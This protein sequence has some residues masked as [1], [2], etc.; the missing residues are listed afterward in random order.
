MKINVMSLLVDDQAKA[1]RFYTEQLGFIKK[2]D[3]PLG[4]HKWLTVVSNEERDGVELLLEPI[5]FPPAQI[6][7]KALFDAGIPAAS[8]TVDDIHNE[9][10]RLAKAGVQFSMKPTVMGPVTLAVFRDTCGNNIQIVQV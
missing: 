4:D 5:A 6:Y 2:T 10:D 7:Q 9:Y 1:L 8:F 3:L